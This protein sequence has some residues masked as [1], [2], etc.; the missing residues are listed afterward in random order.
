MDVFVVI[1][2]FDFE[3]V[4]SFK[5]VVYMLRFI[6]L[7]RVCGYINWCVYFFVDGVVYF[8][9]LCVVDVIEFVD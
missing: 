1:G 2:V 4:E 7:L 6:V 9:L 8:S 3:I 5:E